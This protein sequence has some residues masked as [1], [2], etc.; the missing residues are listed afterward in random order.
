MKFKIGDKVKFGN[1]KT[2]TISHIVDIFAG[3]SSPHFYRIIHDDNIGST[4]IEIEQNI[5]LDI[6]MMRAE[7]LEQ[8]L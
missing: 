3:T 1:N 7:K 8:L 6:A 4:T 5:Q 2:G